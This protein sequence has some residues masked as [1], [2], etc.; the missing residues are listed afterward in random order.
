MVPR[1]SVVEAIRQA[2]ATGADSHLVEI[3]AGAGGA[4]KTL[5]ETI[6]AFANGDGGLIVLGMDERRGF[7]VV[8]VNAAGL[9]DALATACA[10]LVEPPV[11]AEIEVMEFEGL[12]IVVAAIPAA[13]W[14][15]KP[16]FVKSQGLDRGSYIRGHDG[17]RHLSTYEIHALIAG[18]GQPK[19]DIATVEGASAKDLL[20][21]EVE[22]YLRRLR[23]TRGQIFS[24]LGDSQ[25]LGMTGVL[26]PD[27]SGVTVAGLLAFGRYPQ[28][29]LPQ[30]NVTFVAFP[31][32]DARPMADGTRFLDNAAL[33]GPIPQMVDNAW[34][35]LS[36]NITRGAVVT[37]MGRQDIWEYPPRAVRE[38]VANALMHRDYHSLAQGSQVRM[39]LYPDRL[40]IISPGGLFGA[41]NAEI[42]QRSPVTSTRNLVLAKLLE[43]VALPHSQSTVAENRGTGLLVVASELERSG[44]PPLE[45]K[46]DQLHFQATIRRADTPPNSVSP[47]PARPEP[48]ELRARQQ[49]IVGLLAAGPKATVELAAAMGLT[50][51]A[52]MA[53][54][55]ALESLGVV[56][57]TTEKRTASGAK[58][59]V[60][61]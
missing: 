51:T 31:T 25:I 55:K 59:R 54:L 39:E 13:G 42:L 37:G 2:R 19:D 46:T 35:A 33:D 61:G 18:R 41:V 11:R 60:A 6:S 58:W 7:A 34:T 27:G 3:K 24:E 1:E 57:L 9:A 38:L 12:M 15:K 56:A 50:R 21:S 10:T 36:R 30:M 8:P 14:D 28:Q 26:T 45:I 4:P 44:L 32:A 5:P 17:D 48:L 16:C 43:D 49:Q 22:A 53:H 29:Y 40:S 52:V 20:T 23:S 47:L